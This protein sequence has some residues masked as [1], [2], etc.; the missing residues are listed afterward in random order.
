MNPTE[1]NNRQNNSDQ[2]STGP[3]TTQPDSSPPESDPTQSPQK[4]RRPFWFRLLRILVIAYGV[5][6]LLLVVF[7][8]QL[9]FPGAYMG[10]ANIAGIGAIKPFEYKAIDGSTIN[11]RVLEHPNAMRTILFFHG[12]GIKAAW[13]DDWIVRLS[14]QCRANVVAAEY[15]SYQ[16][17]QITPHETNL[18]ED[19][20]SA[21]DVTCQRFGIASKDLVIY[22]RSLG[23]GVAA[24][25]AQQRE[26]QTLI[27]DRTFDSLAAV[28]ADRY[29]MFPV[30]W[31]IRNRFESSERLSDYPGRLLQV[32]GTP[33]K[34][35][36]IKFGKRL[37]EA[38]TQ[39]DKTFIEVPD[40]RHND[41]MSEATFAKI[42]VW[43]DE[44]E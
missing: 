6:L 15:R 39:A 7:E 25:V 8:S 37:A 44:I 22:G 20:L 31:M 38:A 16:A 33:D 13:M 12:N 9:V 14:S 27:M 36:P 43:L 42:S 35:V 3:N 23:G 5:C 10:D 40:M 28:A 2:N 17:D 32:H 26:T 34:L 41:R 29:W 24:A 18:I 1:A 21:H 11:A 19:G 4:M 30:N